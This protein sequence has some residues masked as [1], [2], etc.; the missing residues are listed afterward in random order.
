MRLIYIRSDGS[1]YYASKELYSLVCYIEHSYHSLLTMSNTIVFGADLLAAVNDVV[2]SDPAIKGLFH[3]C[4]ALI[5]EGEAAV[6]LD[7][8]DE[9]AL[10]KFILD[11]F[12]KL[13]GKDFVATLISIISKSISLQT[14]STRAHCAAAATF[15]REARSGRGGGGGGGAS[16]GKQPQG[17]SGAGD[18]QEASEME[19]DEEESTGVAAAAPEEAQ[20]DEENENGDATCS[21]PLLFECVVTSSVTR[22][23]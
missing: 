14:L 6:R 5:R 8:E 12:L 21:L 1:L 15:A 18:G 19:V 9:T 17:P 4:T 23:R 11:L 16:T 13:R 10:L 3:D 2:Q 22:T 20:L 7:P